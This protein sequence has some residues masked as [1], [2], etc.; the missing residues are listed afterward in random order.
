MRDIDTFEEN[1]P[2]YS[3][4]VFYPA[5]PK[6]GKEQMIRKLDPL[7][8]SEFNYQREHLL[9][10]TEGEEDLRDRRNI[11]NMRR[12]KYALLSHQWRK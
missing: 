8:I 11:K 1:N 5:P 7:R 6:S 2:S 12:A 3:I 4:N 10:F 9:L